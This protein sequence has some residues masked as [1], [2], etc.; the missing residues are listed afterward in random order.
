MVGP[1]LSFDKN[2]LVMMTPVGITNQDRGR[3]IAR[4]HGLVIVR[5]NGSTVITYD[6][7]KVL[8]GDYIQSKNSDGI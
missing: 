2:Q 6:W 5:N 7:K 3:F 1:Q 4:S 8:R